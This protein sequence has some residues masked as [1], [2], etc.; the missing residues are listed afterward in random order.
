M[1]RKWRWEWEDHIAHV[2]STKPTEVVQEASQVLEEHGCHVKDLQSE[3]QHCSMIHSCSHDVHF[4]CPAVCVS[5]LLLSHTVLSKLYQKKLVAETDLEMLKGE[6]RC[7]ASRIYK[8]LCSKPPEV[9][10]RTADVL[11]KFGHNES[12]NKLKGEVVTLV[13]SELTKTAPPVHCT[14]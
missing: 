8:V 13:N 2:M 12:A 10:T 5:V 7:L 9:M 14:S 6:G 1:A 3:F 11:Y 4:V